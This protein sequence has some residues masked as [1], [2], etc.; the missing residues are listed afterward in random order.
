MNQELEKVGLKKNNK[1]GQKMSEI[2]VN[3]KEKRL[4]KKPLK[5]SNILS[6][7]NFEK[8]KITI[9]YCLNKLQ[10]I[11]TQWSTMQL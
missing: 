6:L 8:I 7:D 4:L 11:C 5:N 9:E 3:L 2:R 10:F 1:K